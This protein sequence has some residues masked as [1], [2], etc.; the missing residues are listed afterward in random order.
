VYA[1]V[2]FRLTDPNQ[3]L[4]LVPT[5]VHGQGPFDFILDTGAGT[6]LLSPELA[7]KLDVRAT[8]TKEGAGAGGKVEIEIGQVESI[9]VGQATVEN[10]KVGITQE[11]AKIGAC[12]GTRIDGG[13]GYNFFRDFRLT[14]D[15]RNQLLTLRD[16]R[17]DPDPRDVETGDSV[18][19]QLAHLSK[20]IVVVPVLVNGSGPHPFVL[21]TGASMT[22]LSTHLA[23]D[24]GV[25]GAGAPVLAG[26]GGAASASLGTLRT[27]R[28]GSTELENVQAVISDFLDNLSRMIE[29][30]VKG[31]IGYNALSHFAITIDYP[32][33]TLSI[34]T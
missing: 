20:P 24:L 14:I 6:C 15:Y 25:A 29:T 26:A 31:I 4:I 8:E 30:D 13:L 1:Q 3:P 18:G 33:A 34:Q 19:F 5:L 11:L 12:C 7:R 27:L 2:P 17:F 10:V 16:G 23:K 9:S 32:R 22:V 28:I 21:D